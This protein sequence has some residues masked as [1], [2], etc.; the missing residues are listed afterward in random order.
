MF[1]L[2]F[3]LVAAMFALYVLTDGYDLG[4]GALHL[5][6]ARHDT[7]RRTV[8]A[9]I[10]PY[11]DANEVWL[12][13]AGGSLFVAFPRVLAAGLSGFY[14]AIFIILWCL[15]LRA[16][17]IEFRSHLREPLWRAFWDA[18]FAVA[19]ALLALLFGV[20]LGNV[21]RGVPLTPDGWFKLTLFT[22][23]RPHDPAGILDWYTLL[24]GVFALVALAAHGAAFL[25]WH[26]GGV[27]ADRA[28]RLQVLLHALLLALWPLATVATM[29]VNPSLLAALPGRPLAW[30][31]AVLAAAGLIA[32][33]WAGP[34]RRAAMAF[35]G[36]AAFLG[37]MLVSTAA[38]LFPVLLRALPD[39]ARSI[40]AYAGGATAQGLRTALG[41]W[42]IGIPIAILWFVILHL[43]HR[44]RVEAKAETTGPY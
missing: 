26:S 41:W 18:A 23:F 24:A 6:V 15:A 36:S 11:W 3:W 7:E 32:A 22:D 25:A 38:C 10:G 29:A 30:I 14:L 35:L 31:A 34:R 4:A 12:I 28:R 42:A 44:G 16:I 1:E 27:V 40:T 5:L 13:A 33:L 17:A 19:S 43:L 21:I 20:A 37:G 8:I 39:P 2:W 9:T